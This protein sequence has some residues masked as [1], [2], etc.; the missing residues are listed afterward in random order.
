MLSFEPG[1]DIVKLVSYS[2]RLSMES[3]LLLNV[4]MP[5]IVVILTFITRMNTAAECLKPDIFF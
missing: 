4:K 1:P 5:T 3:M 2:T